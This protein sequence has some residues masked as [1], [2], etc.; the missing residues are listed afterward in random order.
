L[1]IGITNKN[2]RNNRINYH[3]KQGWKL[4][5]L[6]ELPTGEKAHYIE[7]NVISQWKSIGIKPAVSPELAREILAHG[8]RTETASLNEIT[9]EEVVHMIKKAIPDFALLAIP[10]T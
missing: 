5:K 10:L 2:G 6:W 8:G 3:I 4:D 9:I 7:R 1:K